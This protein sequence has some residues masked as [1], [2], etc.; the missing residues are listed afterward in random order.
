MLNSLVCGINFNH[1]EEEDGAC[2]SSSSTPKKNSKRRDNN[3]RDKNPYS[4]RG[5]DKFSELLADLDERRQKLYSKVS[6]HDISFVR[7]TYSNNN[8]FVPIIV[9]V[10]NN[11]NKKKN[12]KRDD[13]NNNNQEVLRHK[14]S[15]SEPMQKTTSTMITT[16]EKES[17]QQQ[18]Q[19]PKVMLE[20]DNNKSKSNFLFSWKRMKYPSFY[21]PAV[22]ILI[23]MFLTVFGRSVTTLCTCVLWYV[24]PTLSDISSSSTSSSSSKPIRKTTVRNNKKKEYVMTEDL[25]SQPKD[26][27]SAKHGHQNSW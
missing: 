17:K 24:V 20:S 14:T 26:R 8:D 13:G 18:Q 5:L 12:S 7:F 2:S 21:V 23:L 27:G 19:K 9:K 4:N 25:N 15:F 3:K 1:E 22:M 11:N 6:P 10:K 16:K